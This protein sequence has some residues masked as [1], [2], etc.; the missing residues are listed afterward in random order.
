VI[1]F[2][3]LAAFDMERVEAQLAESAA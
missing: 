2:P 3:Q 1:L